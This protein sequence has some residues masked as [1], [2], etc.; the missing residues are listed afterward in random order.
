MKKFLK[1]I[2]KP[3]L[4]LLAAAA[5]LAALWVWSIRPLINRLKGDVILPEDIVSVQRGTVEVSLK[6]QG[7]VMAKQ[8]VKVTSKPS[9]ILQAVYVKEGDVVKKGQKLG[10]LKPGR[11][12]FEDFK[13]VVIYA[14]VDG[15]VVKCHADSQ[16]YERD[17]SER[18]LSLPRPGTFLE[19]SYDNTENATCFLRLVNTDTLVIPLYVTEMQV[20]QLKKGMPAEVEVV[21][22]GSDAEP[23]PGTITYVSSQIEKS[24]DRW[25]DSKG[26]LVLVELPRADRNILLGVNTN[27]TVP[28]QKREDVLT[29]P[30]SALF[31]K[32]GKSYVFKYIRGNEATRTEVSTGLANDTTV[33]ITGGL[34][35]NDQVLLAPPYGEAW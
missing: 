19:G 10:L 9:G 16:D 26:F 28:L 14:P 21:S 27:L 11:N 18:N 1:R 24:G 8:D 31:E 22:L 33:E 34:Q 2:W 5:C 15:T 7:T 4:F 29:I 23:F 25:S 30:A 3:L 12:E 6:G 35:E 20:L 32:N 13:P 17:L